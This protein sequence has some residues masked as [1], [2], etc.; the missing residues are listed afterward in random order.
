[1]LSTN[2][3]SA[4]LLCLPL[5]VLAAPFPSSQQ[6]PL[7][8]QSKLEKAGPLSYH[9]TGRF[10]IRIPGISKSLFDEFNDHAKI[11]DIANCVE[12]LEEIVYPFECDSFCKEFPRLELVMQ[13]NTNDDGLA[14]LG[15]DIHGYIAADHDGKKIFVTMAGSH[16][17]SLTPE[18]V[19]YDHACPGCKVHESFHQEWESLGGPIKQVVKQDP[20]QTVVIVGSQGGGAVATLAAADF[21]SMGWNTE[22]TTFGQPMVGNDRYAQ[23]LASKFTPSTY[24]RVNHILDLT[25][26]YPLTGEKASFFLYEPSFFISKRFSPYVPSD[27]LPCTD[28][29]DPQCAVP[30]PLAPATVIVPADYFHHSAN[31]VADE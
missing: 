6:I 14:E 12:S 16:S 28:I 5:A 10:P 26:N 1:M 22:L 19:D 24:R 2:L 18:T 17:I 20:F 25:P 21:V 3:R 27:I 8:T 15:E 23:F 4:A 11:A 9:S 29:S 13:W 30:L 7:D 31:C